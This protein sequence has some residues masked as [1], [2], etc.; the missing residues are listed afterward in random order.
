MPRYKLVVEY[1]GTAFAGW[2]RQAADRS[3]Q[4]ALEE[5]IARFVGGPVRVHCAGRT[6]AGVHATHQVVHLDLDK[7]WRTD[8]VRDAAN[9][10]LRPEPVAV[11]AAA[12][13]G[14]DF[15]ARHS[16]IKRHY[17]YRILNRRSPPALTRGFVWHVPW[18]LDAG[19]MHEAAQLMLG[20][21]DF[22]AFRAAECQANSPV[23]TLDRL[24]VAREGE[25]IVV[26]TAARS[27][28]HH[29]VRGMVGT[30]MLA[31]GGRLTPQGVRD[32]LDSRDRTRCG[33]LAPS[34]G[35]TLI[36]VDYPV[37]FG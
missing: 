31:G 5:A 17:R 15:D 14:P 3:V 24:D 4:Q 19:R 25:E 36:G 26:I 10:H 9:A 13:V 22:S 12:E 2:Q 32:V 33:P 11:I 27:F 21:H 34:G 28:L 23:R 29:Q 35:L 20:R 18:A 8:T 6:D 37:E 30:L 7:P 16:A 1:D